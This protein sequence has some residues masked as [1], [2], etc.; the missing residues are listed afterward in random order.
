MG[1][2]ETSGAPEIILSGQSVKLLRSRT[3]KDLSY[4][5]FRYY[6]CSV[7]LDGFP[8]RPNSMLVVCLQSKLSRDIPDPRDISPTFEISPNGP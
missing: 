5:F 3:T 7:N 4:Q 6:C 1:Y 2:P 8:P